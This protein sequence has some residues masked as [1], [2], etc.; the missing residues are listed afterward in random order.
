PLLE[1]DRTEPPVVRRE[2]H[3]AATHATPVRERSARV[4]TCRLRFAAPN[5]LDRLEREIEHRV[6][7]LH[8][9]L[10]VRELAGL[11]PRSRLEHHH[12]EARG[13]KLLRE[14]SARGPRS[15]DHE[16][17]GLAL[18]ICPL[19]HASCFACV[20][21]CASYQPNGA[22]YV[23]SCSRPTIVHPVPFLLPP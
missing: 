12:I 3:A 21:S 6:L 5:R 11:L 2:V 10:I 9:P 14:H 17:D 20:S 1:V 4:P 16:I 19:R 18:C 13:R 22:A 15:D 7:A 8:G 23:G